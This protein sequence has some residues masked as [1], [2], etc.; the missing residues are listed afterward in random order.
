MA[1]EH[2]HAGQGHAHPG[3]RQY[4]LIGTILAVLTAIE[5][6]IFYLT[7]DPA[8]MTW[9]ILL[10]SSAKFLLVVG[11]FMHLKFDDSRFSMLF[12]FPFFIMVSIAVVLLA[13]F[14]KL[15]R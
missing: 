14:L 15:T 13:G 4:V 9:I 6:G 12:F 7:L 2:A 11:Y 1:T 5:F 8:L 10:L 3:P